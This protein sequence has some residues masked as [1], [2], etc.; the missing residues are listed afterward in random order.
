MLRLVAA[1]AL[2]AL[3][4]GAQQQPPFRT[5]TELVRVDVSVLDGRGRPVPNLTA[6][7]FSLTDDGVPQ[8]IQTFR[9]L[10]MHGAAGPDDDLTL[11]IEP[12]R[13]RDHELARDDVRLFLVFW[14]EFHIAPDPEGKLLRDDLV[15]FIRDGFGATDLVAIMDP[16]THTGDL[17]FSR[18]RYRLANEIT[19]R[20]GRRGVYLPPRNAAEE[21]HLRLREGPEY[22]RSLV[23]VSAL[24]AAALHL[25]TLRESRTTILYVGGEFS[26]GRGTDSFD[27][28]QDVIEAANAS[29]VAIYSIDP[30][31]LR[32]RGSNFRNG[33]LASIAHNTGGESFL[34]N[35][36]AMALGRAVSQSTITYLLGY[37]PTPPRQ[38]GRF[39]EI[40][41]KV[42]GPWQVRARTGYWAPDAASKARAQAEAAEAVLPEPI[43]A[44]FSQLAA[45]GRPGPGGEPREVRTIMV[46]DEASDLLA[47]RAPVF[48]RVRA[49]AEL[50]AALAGDLPPHDG[51]EFTR[52]ER[53]LADVA[54]T[55]GLAQKAT[56]TVGLV[57]RRGKRLTDL[58]FTRTPDGARLDLPLQSIARGD[59]LIAIEAEAGESR[60]AA[61]VPVRIVDR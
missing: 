59:Y 1:A 41:V 26:V 12:R 22:A 54:I 23:A 55:G 14:D 31:G 56:I 11:T 9:M 50:K 48:W 3:V 6:A 27:A 2:V 13:G 7:D 19:M 49:P 44:A 20:R 28:A 36:P 51:R 47:V 5:G 32:V 15:R 8:A 43:D 39:H 52:G 35:S 40:K 33:M 34:S 4:L 61:Y 25:G 10:K 53:I 37:S 57:D 45:L 21:N 38:D 24:K 42:K 29:N 16:W 18:D 17:V 30:Q 46:P 58:P 60:A